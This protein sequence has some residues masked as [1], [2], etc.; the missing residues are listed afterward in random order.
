MNKRRLN[1]L[2]DLVEKIR[3]E[4]CEKHVLEVWNGTCCYDSGDEKIEFC[5][6][7][8]ILQEVSRLYR[9][10]YVHLAI[11]IIYILGGINYEFC[12]CCICPYERT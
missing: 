3:H 8:L 1:K 7:I 11:L 9:R 2:Y 10:E 6:F 4:C 12:M 5:P